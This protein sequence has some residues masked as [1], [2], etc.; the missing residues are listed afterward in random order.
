VAPVGGVPAADAVV[1]GAG[2]NGLVAANLLADAGWSVLV[3]E[4]ADH[5]GGAVHSDES[6]RAGFSTDQFSA[7]YPLGVASPVIT[8]L[9][10]PRW[11]LRWSHA[12][13]VLAHVW[14]DDRA[15]VISRDRERTA[16]SIDSFGAGDGAA[17]LELVATFDRIREP[18]LDVLFSPF[19]PVRPGL[20][21]AR[22]LGAAEALRFARV[23]VVPVRRFADEHF[24]GEAGGLLLA[25]NALHADLPPEG[26]GSAL[27]GWLLAM[28]G[29]TTGFPVPVGGSGQLTAALVDRF[30]SRG[31]QLRLSA[32]VDAI[33]LSAGR[34][35]GVR[36]ADGELIK[37]G[38]ILADVSAP[39]LYADLV[40]LE[41]LP[42]RFARDLASFQWDLP[43]F[44][45][46]WALSGPIPWT[47]AAARGAGTVHLGVD[48]DG[49]TRYAADLATRT[50]PAAPFLLL[51]QMTTA[52]PT[53]SPV[54]TESVWAY[55]HVPDGAHLSPDDVR[56]HTELIE[57]TIERNAPGFRDLVLARTVQA[58]LDLQSADANLRGGA[59]SGG[60]A[61]IH[62][63][64]IFRPIPGLGRAETPIDGLYLASASAHPG[65]GVHGGPGA[66]AA[67]AALS[68]AGFG[69]GL[70]RRALDALLRRLY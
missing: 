8:A 61:G 32:R 43:T 18:F 69:G 14:P 65:G 5:P 31:G 52:D 64:L 33:E 24:R 17:W 48:L 58:P 23:G 45:V 70:K 56:R 28:L 68:R 4:A 42:S 57:A 47:A 13:D 34:A 38:S 25:G 35:I 30:S 40:G 7:F 1:I 27:F 29:Q 20:A 60:T 44:K 62:Q 21:L 49:L 19:P 37:A 3:L 15:A 36:L 26:A 54:G 55:T 59:V 66:N 46:N 16:A 22:R 2:H 10:L 39:S 51:G 9:D 50:M 6:V 41:H 63:Q 53:R 12:P 11:G 67:R